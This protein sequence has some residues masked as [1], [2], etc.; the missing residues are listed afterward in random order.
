MNDGISAAIY[1]SAFKSLEDL[2]RDLGSR[3][4]KIPQW[5]LMGA[6]KIISTTVK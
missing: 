4:T 1:D 6:L 3:V 2:V 5:I